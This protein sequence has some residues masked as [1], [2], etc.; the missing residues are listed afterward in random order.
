VQM[1]QNDAPGQ[2]GVAVGARAVAPAVPD[3]KEFAVRTSL[4]RNSPAALPKAAPRRGLSARLMQFG[5][6]LA[7]PLGAKSTKRQRRETISSIV[8]EVSARV[9]AV[10]AVVESMR[11]MVEQAHAGAYKAVPRFTVQAEARALR[12]EA[13]ELCARMHDEFKRA[14]RFSSP[15]MDRIKAEFRITLQQLTRTDEQLVAVERD[16]FPS[17]TSLRV[18]VALATTSAKTGMA[19]RTPVPAPAPD[20]EEGAVEVDGLVFKPL[21]ADPVDLVLA[22][23][24]LAEVRLIERQASQLREIAEEINALIGRQGETLSGVADKVELSQQKVALGRDEILQAHKLQR[25]RR[26]CCCCSV[27]LFLAIVASA[28][29]VAVELRYHVIENTLRSAVSGPDSPAAPTPATPAAATPA[30]TPLGTRR[31]RL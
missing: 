27:L 30:P 31:R 15:E 24:R 11:R 3:S 12:A 23:E 25:K 29:V 1:L 28:A 2:Q 9:V 20:L 5:A 14:G 13:T 22:K 8:L 16:L 6:S 18:P 19:S 4:R 26:W 17:P 21:S 7:S 10:H